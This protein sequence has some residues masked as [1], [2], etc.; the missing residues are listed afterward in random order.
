MIYFVL[1]KN[2]DAVVLGVTVLTAA[3]GYLM[4][5]RINRW[6]YRHRVSAVFYGSG[7]IYQMDD[8]NYGKYYHTV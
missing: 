4:N 8:R 2:M 1:L 6:D 7:R 3:L 5:Y